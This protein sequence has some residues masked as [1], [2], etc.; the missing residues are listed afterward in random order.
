[1]NPAALDAK[2]KNA[3]RAIDYII[4]N[5]EASRIA[6][7]QALGLSPGTVT[8]IVSELISQGYI[9]ESRQE[10]AVVGR[11]TSILKFNGNLHYVLTCEISGTNGIHLTVS[12]LLGVVLNDSYINCDNKITESKTETLL[13]RE[14]IDCVSS[15]LASQ[16][17]EIRE[18]IGGVG[19]CVGGM[20][21]AKQQIDCP[22]FNWSH[23]NLVS[24]LQAALHIPVYA[25]GITRMKAAYEVTY[26]DPS[27]KNVIY[28]NLSTGIGMVNF[29]NGKMVMGK[30]GISGEIGHMSLNV[31]GP[32][33]YCG[34]RGCFEYYCGMQQILIRA[35]ALLESINSD[36][37]FYDLVKCKGYPIVPET[38]FM[39]REQGSIAIHELFTSVSKYLGAAISTI[40]N[41]YDPDH[42]IIASY[43]DE[44]AAFL[45]DNSIIEARSRIV[46]TFSRDI[47]ISH[48]HLKS[49]DTH[50][51]IS[52]YVRSRLLGSLDL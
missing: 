40:Y 19:L 4:A 5:G 48:A 10:Y 23:V 26:L 12:N 1:M 21:N 47:Q 11:K 33:C 39:A 44:R 28:L 32:L 7:G 6:L 25:E 31:D 24:P 49:H 37:V 16:S 36:D 17:N 29:F 14:I 45:I 13:I 8:N 15:F 20:V 51:A 9:Y 35:G 3:R 41:V 38:L 43:D 18:K 2:R 27:E 46:S 30:Y 42:L 50:L 22:M 52:S 34:N